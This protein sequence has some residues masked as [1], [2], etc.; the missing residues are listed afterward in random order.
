MRIGE[1]RYTSVGDAQV[2]YQVT[3]TGGPFDFVFMLGQDSAFVGTTERAAQR[4]DARWTGLL[5]AHDRSARRIPAEWRGRLVNTTGDG[6]HVGEVEVRENEDL[7]GI[8]VHIAA[9]VQAHARPGEVL[10]SRTVKDLTAGSGIAFEDRGSFD[11]KG[12]PDTWQ[13]FAVT[14]GAQSGWN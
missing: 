5:E 14:E 3:D 7:G 10:C 6:I 9:R 12:V 4:G 8:A 1:T 13:L 2:A 11:L